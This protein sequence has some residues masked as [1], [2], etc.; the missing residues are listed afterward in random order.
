MDDAIESSL[1]I[2][3]GDLEGAGIE[4]QVGV[5]P[6]VD[7]TMSR[8]DLS[9]VIVHLLQN[10]LEACSRG[11]VVSL[12][13]DVVGDQVRIE[14]TDTGHG[15]SDSV[16][17]QMFEPYFTTK[18]ERNASGLGLTFSK[19]LLTEAGGSIEYLGSENSTCFVIH[20][21]CISC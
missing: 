9:Q 7:V 2:V 18:L 14:V 13:C 20:V 1:D 6:D 4:L 16:S 11:S 8:A 10:S 3:A 17:N 15:I 5:I 12:N 19:R 21:P